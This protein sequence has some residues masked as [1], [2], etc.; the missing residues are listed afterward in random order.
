MADLRIQ[1]LHKYY[2]DNHVVKGIHL[3]IPEGEFIVLV[4][5]SGCG[6]STLLRTIA[7][8]ETADQGTIEIAGQAVNDIDRKSTRLNSSH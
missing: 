7:G 4:G 3:E 5:Q 6:K 1:G 2:G 8:L